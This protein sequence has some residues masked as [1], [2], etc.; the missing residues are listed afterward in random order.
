MNDSPLLPDRY[1]NHDLF[2]CD[3]SDAVV[4]DDMASMEHPIFVLTK[5]PYMKTRR[6]K[7]GH[8][9]FEIQPS[10]K[11]VANIWDKD[12]LI[13]AIS[14]I[15]AAKKLGLPYTKNVTFTAYDFLIFSNRKT[16]GKEYNSLKDSL[17]RLGGTQLI[18]NVRTGGEEITHGFG[19]I[20]N[21]T[22]RRE[23][24]NGRVL[25]WGITLSNWL[26]K[27][28]ESNEVLTLNHEYFR[29]KKPLER[30]VYEIARKHCGNK[31]EWR[32][33]LKLL[34]K[35]CGSN[36]VKSHFKRMIKTISEHQHLPDYE[37][38]II[39]DIVLFTRFSDLGKPNLKE[40]RGIDYTLIPPLRTITYEKC[41]KLYS[42]YDPYYLEDEWR[43]WVFDKEVPKSPDAAFLGFCKAY[44]TKHPIY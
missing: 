2:F 25:E 38:D 21:F 15:M 34:Q 36:S 10:A 37:V 16:G 40:R 29:L 14:Q 32:I 44:V 33:S 11:G 24:L 27:A 41:R 22:I 31:K 30:R 3:I 9:W 7:N 42:K 5:Q 28:I 1:K 6:Y 19:L 43:G 35:K 26:F 18:T 23:T 13:Y 39:N 20:D 17:N 8:N 4:K 12:I